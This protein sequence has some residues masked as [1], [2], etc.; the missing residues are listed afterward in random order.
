MM[1][2][3]SDEFWMGMAERYATESKDPGTKVGCVIVRPD[4]TP[5]S[6]GTNGFPQGIADTPER[7]AD[8]PTKLELTVHAEDNALIF[9]PERVVGYTLYS[10]FAP[11]IR[12]AVKIIQA[13]LARVVFP[14]TDNPRW[15]DEQERAVDLFR[16]AGI[17][18]TVLRGED[19]TATMEKA[20]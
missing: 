14:Q 20:A 15:R 3:W 13:K 19:A 12:C 18:V 1:S 10:T 2:R 6:W 5:C 11:C 4:K 17:E 8:R 16:E 9:A 7:I